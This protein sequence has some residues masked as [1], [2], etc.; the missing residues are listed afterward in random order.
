HGESELLDEIV[1]A[2]PQLD[3]THYATPEQLREHGLQHLRDAVALLERKSSPEEVDAYKRFV[4]NLATSVAGAHREHGV[5]ISDKE[6]TTV[7]EI[8]KTLGIQ[9]PQQPRLKRFEPSPTLHTEASSRPPHPLKLATPTAS[10]TPRRA[11]VL[12]AVG[13]DPPDSQPRF[14]HDVF[15]QD[16]SFQVAAVSGAHE[17]TAHTVWARRRVGGS[18]PNERSAMSATNK[19]VVR[20]ALEEPWRNVDVLDELV[21]SDYVGN[22]PALPEPIRGIQGA[23]DNVNQYSS[24]FE[25]A[26]IT[27]SEQ[28]AEGALVAS[29]WEGQG[30]HTGEIMGIAPTGRDVVVSGQTLSR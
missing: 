11:H 3:H 27:V 5:A 20:R 29:R 15:V 18:R 24:A 12:A 4:I 2:K 28:V 13:E 23:K 6:Q 30:R 8:A 26:Q 25:G 14:G 7:D 21:S 17:L 10:R 16:S 22:D 19:D 9:A 1:S